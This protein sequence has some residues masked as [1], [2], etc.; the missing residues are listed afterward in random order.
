LAG[1]FLVKRI[2][3]QTVVL[4]VETGNKLYLPSTLGGTIRLPVIRSVMRS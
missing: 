3:A 4:R 2:F 1:L